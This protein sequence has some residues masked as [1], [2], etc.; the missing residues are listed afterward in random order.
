MFF[1]K[2]VSAWKN[3]IDV[4]Y[5]GIAGVWNQSRGSDPISIYYLAPFTL[6]TYT[7]AP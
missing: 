7:S 5:I 4:D 2:V 6:G 1:G 3:K